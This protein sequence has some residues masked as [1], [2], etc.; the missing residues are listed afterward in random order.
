[1]EKIKDA[2]RAAQACGSE[3][4]PVSMKLVAA[5]RYVLTT[6]TLDKAQVG[7]WAAVWLGAE[8]GLGEAGWWLLGGGVPADAGRQAVPRVAGSRRRCLLPAACRTA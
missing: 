3:A 8:G 2:I 4:C 7:G 5:P 1:M 6:Q